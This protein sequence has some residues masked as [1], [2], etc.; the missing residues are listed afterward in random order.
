MGV[1]IQGN[2]KDYLDMVEALRSG[3]TAAHMKAI[4]LTTKQMEKGE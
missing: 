2:E 1:F 3:G 4:E